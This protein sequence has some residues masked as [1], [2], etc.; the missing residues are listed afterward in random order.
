MHSCIMLNLCNQI[1]RSVLYREGCLG[2]LANCSTDKNQLTPSG[3][4]VGIHKLPNSF[5]QE[6]CDDYVSILSEKPQMG[7]EYELL[8]MAQKGE[9]MYVLLEKGLRWYEI[10]DTQDLA[11]AQIHVEL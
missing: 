6:M 8:R 10:D 4:L 1:A 11:Y 3:E 7:Y 5:Y 9:A 2:Y